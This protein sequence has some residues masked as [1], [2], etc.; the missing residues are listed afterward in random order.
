MIKAVIFDIDN[1][2]YNY[3]E[4]H[5]AA[6]PELCRYVKEQFGWDAAFFERELSMKVV[7]AQ[8]R[9]ILCRMGLD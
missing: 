8:L 4:A 3:D 6:F 9:D 2:L 5:E 7:T 1:T